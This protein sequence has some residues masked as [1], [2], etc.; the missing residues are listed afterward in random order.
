MSQTVRLRTRERRKLPRKVKILEVLLL[1]QAQQEGA[2][3]PLCIL[4]HQADH[5]G[6]PPSHR[7]RASHR[8]CHSVW[9]SPEAHARNTSGLQKQSAGATQKPSTGD[10]AAASAFQK[11]LYK[12]A[13]GALRQCC[14]SI[15]CSPEATSRSTAGAFH[16][17]C[18][19]I[20]CSPEATSRSTSGIFHRCCHSTGALQKQ[21]PEAPREPS[22]G[23]FTAYGAHQKLRP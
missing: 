15:W 20:W 12:S 3:V 21:H 5:V 22:T 7:V 14:H 19:S 11:L 9:C 8:R 1:R 23:A 10:V 13:S 16:R 4:C 18:H 6:E 17:C 2:L